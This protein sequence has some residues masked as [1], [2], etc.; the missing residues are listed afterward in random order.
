MEIE[1]EEKPPGSLFV[2][3]S[4]IGNNFKK[5]N[6]FFKYEGYNPTGTQ[7]DRISEEHVKN[8]ISQEYDTISVATCGNYGVSIA[9]Y[10]NKYGI[11]AIVGIPSE[12]SVSRRDEIA[13]YGAELVEEPIKYEEMVDLIRKRAKIHS[14]YDASPGSVNSYID[15][16]SYGNIANEIYD[17]MKNIPD[18]V[19]VPVGNGTT[20]YG[21]YTGFQNL[22]KRKLIDKIPKFIAN[23]T[24]NGNPIIYSFLNGF[25]KIRDLNPG[26]IKETPIDEPLVAYRSYDGQNALDVLY[27]TH[28]YALYSTDDEMKN[29]STRLMEFYNLSVLPASCSALSGALRV[30]NKETC[31]VLLTGKC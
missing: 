9:Y 30:I 15:Y 12:Y 6:L 18:Y 26:N 3:E 7:K 19:S 1:T 25:K 17:S 5:P 24:I 10:A 20:L 29:L 22:Y 16:A 4:D 28:G 2:R 31:V 8:A 11:K 23:S 21:I 27:E 14:W 13:S